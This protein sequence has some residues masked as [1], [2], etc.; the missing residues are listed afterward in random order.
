[1]KQLFLLFIINLF[2][3][4]TKAAVNY[5]STYSDKIIVRIVKR[6][7]KEC[8]LSDSSSQ[9]LITWLQVYRTKIEDCRT[10]QEHCGYLEIELGETI[11]KRFG[12]EVYSA[13]NRTTV[14][15]HKIANRNKRKRISSQ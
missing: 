8:Y 4:S 1:M 13:C 3:F 2:Q 5:D 14:L 6:I 11:V 7:L 15:I 12:I 10:K 9:E